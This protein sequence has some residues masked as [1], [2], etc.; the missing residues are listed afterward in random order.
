LRRGEA[1]R[2]LESTTRGAT[3]LFEGDALRPVSP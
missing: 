1:V 2:T 3:L